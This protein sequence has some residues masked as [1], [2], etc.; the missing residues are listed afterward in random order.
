MQLS[1]RSWVIPDTGA[2][3]QLT[4]V[5]HEF[6]ACCVTLPD[7]RWPWDTLRCLCLHLIPTR[8]LIP[9]C[10]CALSFCCFKVVPELHFPFFFYQLPLNPNFPFL[11]PPFLKLSFDFVRPYFCCFKVVPEHDFPFFLFQFPLNPNFPFPSFFFL[12]SL[13]R[14]NIFMN[15]FVL[16]LLL[17]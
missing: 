3:R 1:T 2:S 15:S 8:A 7:T 6:L 14:C 16:L 12:F 10:L 4:S 17:L 11:S 5:C 9:P 13:E